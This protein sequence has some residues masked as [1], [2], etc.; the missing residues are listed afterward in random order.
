MYRHHKV[1]RMEA[2]SVKVLQELFRL[3]ETNPDILPTNTRE[4]IKG[5]AEPAR[6]VICDYIAG[7]TD[8][9]A[10]EEYEKLTEPSVRV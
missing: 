9:F 1:T 5:K 8:R 3:Y 7:M 4:K 6:R 10:I 2:K